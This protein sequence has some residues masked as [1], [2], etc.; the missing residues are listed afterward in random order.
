VHSAI[1]TQSAIV[2]KAKCKFSPTETMNGSM[3]VSAKHAQMK[4]NTQLFAELLLSLKKE[5]VTQVQVAKAIGVP[6]QRITDY[7]NG[8]LRIEDEQLEKAA[9]HFNYQIKS[10]EL[11]K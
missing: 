9:K 10:A 6:K 2:V 4:S 8:K 11:T 1:C 7:K 3:S 5:K